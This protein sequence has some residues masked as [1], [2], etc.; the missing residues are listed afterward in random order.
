M[1][2]SSIQ[3]AEKEAVKVS[4][5]YSN[6]DNQEGYKKINLLYNL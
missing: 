3:K 6:S 5:N 4:T 1:I 2:N